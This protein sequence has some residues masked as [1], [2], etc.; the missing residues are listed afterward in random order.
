MGVL[1]LAIPVVILAYFT[2]GLV[3]DHAWWKTAFVATM[4][5]TWCYM[6]FSWIRIT[7]DRYKE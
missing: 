6:E 2:V 1:F 4:L 7:I 5:A 3:L